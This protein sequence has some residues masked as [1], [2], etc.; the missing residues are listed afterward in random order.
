MQ[1]E[2]VLPVAGLPLA[3]NFPEM[4]RLWWSVSQPDQF[5]NNLSDS[6]PALVDASQVDSLPSPS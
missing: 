5:S 3:Q 6:W 2:R 1:G 4:L